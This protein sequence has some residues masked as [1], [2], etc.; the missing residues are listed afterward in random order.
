MKIIV[1]RSLNLAVGCLM[2]KEQ[3]AVWLISIYNASNVF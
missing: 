1:G 3:I 2:K